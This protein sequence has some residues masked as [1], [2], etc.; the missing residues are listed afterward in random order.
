[1]MEQYAVLSTTRLVKAFQ[2]LTYQAI[3]TAVLD[4]HWIIRARQ[5]SKR[6]RKM[7]YYTKCLTGIL[8]EGLKAWA[9]IERGLF[10]A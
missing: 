10:P 8:S 9:N 7:M 4:H 1:M 5:K 3:Q 2:L 6:A